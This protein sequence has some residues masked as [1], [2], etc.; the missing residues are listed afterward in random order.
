MKKCT[1]LNIIKKNKSK[2]IKCVKKNARDTEEI[3]KNKKKK[4][5]RVEKKLKYVR[6]NKNKL[7]RKN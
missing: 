2:K 1:T 5:G 3:V 6:H 4:V 7:H